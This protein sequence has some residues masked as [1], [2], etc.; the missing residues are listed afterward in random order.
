M[1]LRT[2]QRR[3]KDGSTVRYVQLAHN[4]RDGAST[5]AK[6]LVNLG[7]ED[8]LDMEGLRRLTASIDRYLDGTRGLDLEPLAG[9]GGDLIG[10]SV[11]SSRPIGTAWLLDGLWAQLDIAAALTKHIDGRRFRTDIERIVFAMVAGRA[12]EPD[13][14][15]A[16]AEWA[17]HDV[18]IPGL[19]SMT[20]DQAVRAMDLL[21][22]ADAQAE[23]QEAVFF[24]TAHLLNLEVDFLLLDTTSTY[25][26]LDDPDDPDS[27][28]GSTLR[29]R[30]HSKDHRP[31]LPQ[32]VIGLAVTKE[33]IPVRIWV[34]P[35]N[36]NDQTVI[37]QVKDDLRSWRLGRVVTVA[38]SGFSGTDNLA[39]L[40]RAGGHFI[41]GVKMR[42]GSL[43]AREALSRQGRHQQ[44]TDR[45]R[46][47]EVRLD[48][49][50]GRRWIICH[51][52][53]EADRDKARR[54]EH[55]AEIT[56]ELARI[57]AMRAADQR[58]AKATAAKTGKAAVVGEHAPHRKAECALRDHPSLGRLLKQHPNTGRLSID[59]AKVAT[60][61]N[62]DGKYL[63]TTSDPDLAPGDVATAY[64]NL[65]EVERSFRTMK[66]TLDLRPVYHRLD[67]RIRAHVLLCWMALL[68]IRVAETRTG[69]R[70][71]AIEREM[72]RLHQVVLAGPVGR[73]EQTTR[74]TEAQRDIFKTAGITPPPPFTALEP[75]EN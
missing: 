19:A 70:W 47:K 33:G 18:V 36:T 37:T 6:V 8:G 34:W 55:L 3:N 44:I 10:L 15:R 13:S 45:L 5:T 62:L 23:V 39:Y 17:G 1:Y 31:D 67:E 60:E 30:G 75:A 26:E 68:L 27:A 63:I 25:F 20:K 35:G 43:A 50:P 71:Q 40:T 11:E 51:N 12:I 2:T 9:P 28:G 65:L 72:S 57:T 48:D 74:L 21:I 53:A 4:V 42:E 24:A 54:D 32:I 41:T 52:P 64:K 58:K 46:V 38:D 29:R 7:R 69:R 73:A 59:R 66:T 22:E 16:T 14:K 49:T 61:A 56:T